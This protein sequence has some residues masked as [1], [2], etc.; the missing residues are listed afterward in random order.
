MMI[1]STVGAAPY[2]LFCAEIPSTHMSHSYSNNY[3]HVVY[4]TKNRQDLIPTKFEKRLYSFIA[5]I[6][7]EHNCASCCGRDAEP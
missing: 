2:V 1:R 3:V 5:S 6:A 7:R 4:S